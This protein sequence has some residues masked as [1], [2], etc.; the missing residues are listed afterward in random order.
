[1]HFRAKH[2]CTVKEMFANASSASAAS[3]QSS[4]CRQSGV[5]EDDGAYGSDDEPDPFSA[6]DRVPVSRGAAAA[7]ETTLMSRR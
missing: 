7:S 1:M 6:P 2:G 5:A 4:R 3:A